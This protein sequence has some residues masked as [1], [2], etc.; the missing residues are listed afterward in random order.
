MKPLIDN[1]G[2]VK[3]AYY[4]NK[5]AFQKAWAG[6]DNVDVVYGPEDL[7]EPVIHYIGNGGKAD[8]IISLKTVDGKQLET[9]YFHDISL[10]RI[11]TSKKLPGFRFKT[12]PDNNYVIDYVLIVRDSY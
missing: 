10:E 1:G 3:L 7:I 4:T 9:K 6:S 12:R 2:H 5:M 11:V 8:L